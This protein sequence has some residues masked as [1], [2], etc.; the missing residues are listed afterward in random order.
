[1]HDLLSGVVRV[2]DV[3]PGHVTEKLATFEFLGWFTDLVLFSS[4]MNSMSIPGVSGAGAGIETRT[5]TLFLQP[6]G[7]ICVQLGTDREWGT[8]WEVII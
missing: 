7:T 3:G 5:S 1:M 8:Y 4:V 6:W 2:D